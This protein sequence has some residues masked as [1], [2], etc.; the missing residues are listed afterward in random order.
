[1]PFGEKWIPPLNSPTPQKDFHLSLHRCLTDVITYPF[2]IALS[3]RQVGIDVSTLERPLRIHLL[4]FP[5]TDLPDTIPPKVLPRCLNSILLGHSGI[6]ITYIGLAVDPCRDA[7]VIGD[8]SFSGKMVNGV[9]QASRSD[10]N[11]DPSRNSTNDIVA[12]Y[13]AHIAKATFLN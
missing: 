12:R 5:S 8:S 7:I 3:L 6:E 9:H 2:T 10:C 13:N 11:S 4:M 1:M